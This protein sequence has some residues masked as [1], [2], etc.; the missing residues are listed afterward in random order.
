MNIVIARPPLFDEI[1]AAFNVAG[2][3]VF[4]CF[5]PDLYNPGGVDIPPAIIAHERIHSLQQ[6]DDV[7]G[8][9]RKY[10][11]DAAFRLAQEI[12]AH[13][14]E[15]EFICFHGANRKHRRGYLDSIARRLSGPLYGRMISFDE[16]KRLIARGQKEAA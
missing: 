9:W 4:Y 11:A 16:A 15:F 10:I 14:R 8:W 12:P 7:T 2:K 3:D 1:N 5:G 13:Q 6:G